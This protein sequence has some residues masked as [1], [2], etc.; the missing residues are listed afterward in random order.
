MISDEIVARCVAIHG[1]LSGPDVARMRAALNRFVELTTGRTAAE[2]QSPLDIMSP[3]YE[4]LA[5]VL[6]RALQQADSGKGA[7]RHGRGLPF[8]DQPM[9]QIGKW[10]G[11]GGPAFQAIKKTQEA[12]GMVGRGERAAAERE[13]LGAI[14]YLAGAVLLIREG[15]K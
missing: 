11:P 14:N 3:G 13:L 1:G 15:V 5:E 2:L 6:G 4:P 8:M 12:L 10:T 7:E 9:I